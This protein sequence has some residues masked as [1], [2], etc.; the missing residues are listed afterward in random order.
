MERTTCTREVAPLVSSGLVEATAGSDR[1]RR[2]LHLTGLGQRR[3]ADARPAWER[4]QQ[5]VAGEVGDADLRDL[6]ARLDRLLESSERLREG[7]S[8]H[9]T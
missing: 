6:L 1:R 5:M 7:V 9:D 2:L 3:L 4:V 8:D